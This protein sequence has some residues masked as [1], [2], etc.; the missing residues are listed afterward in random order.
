VSERFRSL[1]ALRG[2][3]ILVM[4]FVNDLAGVE[5]VPAWMEH[6]SRDTDGMTFV[7]VVFPA[8]LFIVGTSIPLALGRRFE[9]GEP[10]GRIW[11]H[12]LTR[13]FALLLIGIFMV[14]GE[15]MPD[16]GILRPAAW[17]LLMYVG[18]ILA[19]NV[20]PREPGRGRTTAL[21][22]R[23]LGV[24]LLVALA[25]LFRGSGERRLVELETQWWGILG[26]I[27]WA[28]LVA[29]LVYA[30]FRKS[31]AGVIG[32]IALLYCVFMANAVGAFSG[33]TWITD[34][35]DIGSMWGSHAAITLS[36]V[37]LGMVLSQGSGVTTPAERIR[38]AVLFGLGLA[39]AGFLLHAAHDVHSMFR[40]SKILATPPWCLVSSAITVWVWA[41]IYWLMDVRA[42]S[43]W[44]TPLEAAG[45]NALFAYVL[46]PGIVFLLELIFA[47]F[48]SSNYYYALGG[49]FAVGL[50]RSAV[51]AVVVT[52]LAGL[53]A[54]SGVQLRL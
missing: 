25:L 26:L 50:A 33:L 21:V 38:W 49:S 10:R 15:G 17:N 47:A 1:D 23:V 34:W 12:V 30:A 43:R 9:R 20:V 11:R 22:A 28:Y 41:L 32:A 19:W 3:D 27:G 31:I 5:G 54:R 4:I 13:T 40:F 48:G 8:F 18:V 2:L 39:A 51:F 14:N 37:V 42:W 7:D 24:V 53:L 46:A 44:A 45:Q 52:W 29:C 16:T 35:V 36:G 6:V